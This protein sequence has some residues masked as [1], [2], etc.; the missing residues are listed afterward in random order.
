MMRAARTLLA[1][2]AML[3][4]AAAPAPAAPPA[5]TVDAAESRL[6]FT[7]TQMG[8]KFEGRFQRFASAIAFAP[9]D[10]AASRVIVTIDMASADTANRDRD[11]LLPQRAWFDV[12]TS[13]EGRF[14]TTAFRHLGG[15]RYE[16]TANL[17]IRGRAKQVIAPFTIDITGDSARVAGAT[18]LNRSDFGVG[19]GEWASGAVVGLDVE[20]RF[21]LSARRAP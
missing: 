10:L 20:V 14:E 13:P 15:N 1:A 21:T 5:W 17:T 7:G 4:A 9:D 19:E 11:G 16:A 6:T 18:T 8:A 2:A 3:L 12:A